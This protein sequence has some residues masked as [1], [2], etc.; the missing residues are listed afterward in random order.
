[1]AIDDEDRE[2][3]RSAVGEVRRVRH[4]RV[5]QRG[6]PPSPVPAQRRLDEAA[7][8][9]ELATGHFDFS[10]VETGE[11]LQWVRPGM[12][13]RL[14]NRLRRG[15]WRVQDEIDLH[16]MNTQA[17]AATIRAFLKEAIRDG[18][19]CV[20]IIHG[21]GLRSGP[22]GPRIK[23]ITARLLA[24]HDRVVAFAS[25]PPHD[26]GTGAVYVLLRQVA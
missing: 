18:L 5:A 20:K 6:T 8:M 19:S 22:D 26:G 12:R 13:P 3:F 16:Q 7:V 1:M 14:V 2:L 9:D 24:R 10:S 4:E 15:H 21:K 17:A 11:E 25:A 23:Q